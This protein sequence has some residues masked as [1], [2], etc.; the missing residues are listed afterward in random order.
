VP[1]SAVEQRIIE[2]AKACCERWGFERV[3]VDDI[4]AE[5]E[6]SRATLYRLFPGGKDV[7]FEALR[8]QELQDFF[9]RLLAAIGTTDSLEDLLVAAVSSAMRDMRADE[10]LAVMLA[11]APG[12]T[13]GEMTV[14]GMPRIIRTASTFL[15][16]LVEPYLGR[17]EAAQV[18]ELCVRLV[19]SGFLAPSE[20][21][22]F[23]EPDDV[24]R[25]VRKFILP[26]YNISPTGVLTRSTAQ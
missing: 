14:S 11:T 25:F 16:P 3:T 24:R 20:H 15:T 17:R 26:A 12:E 10:H 13:L 9:N 2:A 23:A 4:A 1:H 22:D 5:A 19:I 18:V 6:V 7:L 8:V 21:A